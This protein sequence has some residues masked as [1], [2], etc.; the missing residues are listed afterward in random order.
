MTIAISESRKATITESLISHGVEPNEQA[1]ATVVELMTKNS[2]LGIKGACKK[3]AQAQGQNHATNRT[4]AKAA[5]GAG[6]QINALDGMARKMADGMKKVVGAKAINYLVEDI[7]TGDFG[8]FFEAQLNEA[9]GV[10]DATLNAEYEL[11]AGTNTTPL[12]L[13]SS[14]EEA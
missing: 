2:Q 8:D 10:F 3:I 14:V 6:T 11:I 5:Q 13:E 7:S 4:Q 1:I 12:L 9:F